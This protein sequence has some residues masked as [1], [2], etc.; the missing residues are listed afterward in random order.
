MP[1]LLR[2]LLSSA[3]YLLVELFDLLVRIEQ[4][5]A[6]LVEGRKHRRS[7]IRGPWRRLRATSAAFTFETV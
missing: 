6:G 7:L 4:V 1:G 3:S 2:D 5:L